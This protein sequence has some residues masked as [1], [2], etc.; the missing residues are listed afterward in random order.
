M[1]DV[2]ITCLEV[3][4]KQVY[5]YFIHT[6][7]IPSL[8]NKHNS[9]GKLRYIWTLF[10]NSEETN[11]YAIYIRNTYG[12][13]LKDTYN[14]NRYNR[15]IKRLVRE[16]NETGNTQ[17]IIVKFV[18]NLEHK[19]CVP[20]LPNDK[21]F[22]SLKSKLHVSVLKWITDYNDNHE[23]VQDDEKTDD[24]PAKDEVRKARNVDLDYP[25]M[26]DSSEEV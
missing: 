15:G 10:T 22:E 7:D 16:I 14:H 26:S 1:S 24:L 3:I 8:E 4:D 19:D 20:I 5:K 6:D 23:K 9:K 12:S 25:D 17:F 11:M 2:F 13:A 21:I 18:G